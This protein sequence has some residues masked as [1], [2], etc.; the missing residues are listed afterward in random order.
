MELQDALNEI[1]ELT[2]YDLARMVDD[3]GVSTPDSDTSPGAE[4]LTSIRDAVTEYFDHQ[5]DHVDS[6]VEWSEEIDSSV[7][8]YTHQ[9]WKTFIDVTAYQTEWAEEQSELSTQAAMATLAMLAEEL[10]QAL[11][12]E[13]QD[14]VRAD[15]D[16]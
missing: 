10:A 7:P 2:A 14:Q 4:F 8:V 1:N 16:D 12:A 15:D 9:V 11:H 5:P 3:T 6:D 13:I